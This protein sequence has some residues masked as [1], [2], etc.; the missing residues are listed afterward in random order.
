MARSIFES[1]NV[2][3]TPFSDHFWKFRGSK[4]AR[5]CGAKH[6]SKSKSIKHTLFS[7]HFWKLRC[8][9]SARRCGTKSSLSATT[10]MCI[11]V[12]KAER[13]APPVVV[14]FSLFS[15]FFSFSFYFLHPLNV[16]AP[17]NEKQKSRSPDP[18]IDTVA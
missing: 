17:K 3:N 13:V 7:D 6:I 16:D 9:K 10:G 11:E 15:P 5:S 14:F 1:K 18:T 12:A 4:S 2:Q 8:R